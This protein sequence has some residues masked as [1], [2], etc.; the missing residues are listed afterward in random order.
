MSIDYQHFCILFKKTDLYYEEKY[1]IINSIK[2]NERIVFSIVSEKQFYKRAYK[3]APW[4]PVNKIYNFL[5][6]SLYHRL[7]CFTASGKA[8]FWLRIIACHGAC[9]TSFLCS[10]L[11]DKLPYQPPVGFQIKQKRIS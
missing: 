3:K 5:G 1:V 2:N 9:S 4:C 11:A 6:D 7:R 10:K 8:V